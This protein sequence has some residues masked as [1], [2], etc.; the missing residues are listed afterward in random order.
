VFII[1]FHESGEVEGNPGTM[2][3]K[4]KV[5]RPD[6]KQRKKKNTGTRWSTGED[7]GGMI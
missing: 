7:G 2:M 4:S 5:A 1:Y 3:G 6:R